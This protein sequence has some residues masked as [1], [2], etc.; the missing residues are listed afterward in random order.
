MSY[1]RCSATQKKTAEETVPYSN[2]SL[3]SS[4]R[5]RVSRARRHNESAIIFFARNRTTT[6]TAKSEENL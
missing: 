4:I 6:K 5:R 1:T 2:S 3:P